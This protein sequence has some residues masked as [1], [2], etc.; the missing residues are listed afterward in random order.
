MNMPRALTVFLTA[1]ALGTLALAAPPEG[2]GKPDKAKKENPAHQQDSQG[3]DGG[4]HDDFDFDE[5]DFRVFVRGQDYGRYDS[6]PP[7]IRKN[8]ARGKPLPPGLAKRDVPPDLL[9]RLP[10]REGY[11]WRAV[12][13]DLVLYSITSG[14]IDQVLQDVFFD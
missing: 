4:R 11:E 7:G 2:K 13:T 1:M 5:D 3:H 9:R 14:L 8:L 10:M 6:L 12:G